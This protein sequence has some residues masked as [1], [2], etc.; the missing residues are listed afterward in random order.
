MQGEVSKAMGYYGGPAGGPAGAQGGNGASSGA[1]QGLSQDALRSMVASAMLQPGGIDNS[2]LMTLAVMRKQFNAAQ[3]QYGAGAQGP[4]TQ[5]GTQFIGG[6]RNSSGVHFEGDMNGVN[7]SFAQKLG[8]AASAVG[9]TKIRVR[10]G[11][12]S[13]EHNKAVGGVPNSNHMTGHAMD[14]EVFIPGHGWVPLGVA[15]QGVAPKFGLR[16]GNVP[17]FYRGGLDPVHVDDGANQR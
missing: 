3:K 8:A 4:L 11:Y 1:V 14:G 12:R 17:G 15:L 13:P 2:S 7:P 9:G 6:P 10:S 5:Q 16:S